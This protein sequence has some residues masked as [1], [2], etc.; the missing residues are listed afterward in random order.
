MEADLFS[1]LE[2]ERKA[3]KKLEEANA[4]LL[5]CLESKITDLDQA[6]R[7]LLKWKNSSGPSFST[8]DMVITLYIHLMCLSIYLFPNS[9]NFIHMTR[10]VAC[11]IMAIFA[12][13]C[14][15]EYGR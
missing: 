2:A 14:S 6:N 8:G 5:A 13:I 4:H 10:F 1:T 11:F 3:Y 15:L 12:S 9:A 7:D